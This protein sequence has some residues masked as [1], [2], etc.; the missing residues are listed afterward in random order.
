M[1]EMS[2]SSACW[3]MLVRGLS[4]GSIINPPLFVISGR[5]RRRVSELLLAPLRAG[6]EKHALVKRQDGESGAFPRFVTGRFLDNDNC[7][8]AVGLVLRHNGRLS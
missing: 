2:A 6:Y 5:W 1:P 4:A 3:P 8:G 7:M